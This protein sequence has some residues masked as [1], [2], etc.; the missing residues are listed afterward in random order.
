MIL[1]LDM[2]FLYASFGL[3][4]TLMLLVLRIA[5]FLNGDL[6][7]WVLG[8]GGLLFCTSAATWLVLLFW[9]Q[10][11]AK[12][13][14]QRAGDDRSAAWESVLTRHPAIVGPIAYY[15]GEYR[16]R[17]G[18]EAKWFKRLARSSAILDS[19]C[20]V[21]WYGLVTQLL[22]G[23][24]FVATVPLTS[25]IALFFV[26]VAAFLCLIPVSGVASTLLAV[27]LFYDA[28]E[29][30]TDSVEEQADRPWRFSPFFWWWWVVGLRRYYFESVRP[31][32]T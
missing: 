16:T 18:R 1:V 7:S 23:V 14:R 24:A 22:L 27:V 6:P 26:F 3:I 19:L 29:L 13:Q 8:W 12:R 4:A 28:I 2:L 25:S 15:L 10:V 31:R 32:L 9:M 11:S 5:T 20:F 17:L 30:G 21:A